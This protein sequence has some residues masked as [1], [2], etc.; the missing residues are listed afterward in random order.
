VKSRKDICLL[1]SNN[2]FVL[3]CVHCV[4]LQAHWRGYLLRKRLHMAMDYAR[5]GDEDDD[6]SIYGEVNM[7]D[8][9]FSEVCIRCHR[10][11]TH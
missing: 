1:G 4:Y 2:E 3:L 6:D 8:F 5:F 9:D 11:D 7:D 10:I